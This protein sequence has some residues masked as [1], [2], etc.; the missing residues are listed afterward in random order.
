M[1]R[2][3]IGNEIYILIIS[4]EW[5]GMCSFMVK[6]NFN[7]LM[8]SKNIRILYITYTKYESLCDA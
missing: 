1:S 4:K 6:T 7:L 2:F 8:F 3:Y 5:E